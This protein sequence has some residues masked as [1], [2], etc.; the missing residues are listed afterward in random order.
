MD[1]RLR[2]DEADCF[3]VEGAP[4]GDL[5]PAAP[6]ST[7]ALSDKHREDGAGVFEGEGVT[8]RDLSEGVT[9]G[10]VEEYTFA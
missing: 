3:E 5:I 4:A 2:N 10:D 8:A 7:P 6:S 9:A 1:A